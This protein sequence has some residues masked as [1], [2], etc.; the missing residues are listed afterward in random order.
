MAFK[1]KNSKQREN[2][3]KTKIEMKEEEE[4]IQIKRYNSTHARFQSEK[5]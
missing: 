3:T 4:K 2:G 5:V 1:P